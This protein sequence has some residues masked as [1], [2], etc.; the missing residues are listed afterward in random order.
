MSKTQPLLGFYAGILE[1]LNI[2]DVSEG[3][4][5][6]K[7]PNENDE[8]SD[9]PCLINGKRVVLPTD[10]ILRSGS[11]EGMIAFHPLSENM[12]RGESEIVK[13]LR[14]MIKFRLSS[15]SSQLLIELMS[16]AAD[17]ERHEE[18]SPR[19][20]A[21]LQSVPNANE[22]TVKAMSKLLHTHFDDLLNI[23]LKR[24]DA[25][26]NESYRRLA[27]VSFPIWDELSAPGSKVY[28]VD[29]GSVKNKKTIA[30]LFEYVFPK[31]DDLEEWSEG[32][33]SGTAPYFDSLMKCYLNIGRH[34]AKLVYKYRKYLDHP[35]L[36]RSNLDWEED[37]DQLDRWKTLIPPLPGNEGAV[38]KG[39][40]EP[41]AA[42]KPRGQG[43]R[44][45]FQ[46][47]AQQTTNA[48]PEVE[49]TP[50]WEE[51]PVPQVNPN[52]EHVT[53]TGTG[54]DWRGVMQS[55]PPTAQ[56]PSYAGGQ[57]AQSH[58]QFQMGNGG[59][60]QQSQWGQP[61]HAWQGGGGTSL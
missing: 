46:A 34:L 42:E 26:S 44:P 31:P 23:Y 61:Q 19:Q 6:L 47:A 51:Q 54:L 60:P 10:K 38:A 16:I 43:F 9:T 52:P 55:R 14:K 18:L 57:P 48:A 30:S 24:P 1:S 7:V 20:A 50:P 11:L 28:E 2:E 15:V 40:K 59:A 41:V 53:T 4:L 37:L 5:S 39:E 21:Y 3:R 13:F 27:A 22:K 56:V 36:Q 45:D 8:Y 25:R 33:N 58:T 12:L 32:S 35:D 49:Y 29:C 17:P